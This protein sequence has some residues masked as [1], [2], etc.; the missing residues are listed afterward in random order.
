MSLEKIFGSF[1]RLFAG[2][3]CA[4]KRTGTRRAIAVAAILAVS[5]AASFVVAGTTNASGFTSELVGKLTGGFGLFNSA[6]PAAMATTVVV[7]PESP[8]GWTYV[9]EGGSP[10]GSLVTG[11]GTPPLGIG[12]AQFG[13]SA[14]ADGRYL[15]RA[16]FLGTPLTAIT[17]ISYST[18]RTS[19]TD[20]AYAAAFSFNV[21]FDLT[22]VNTGWQGR[23][24]YE[25]YF[26][27]TVTTGAWQTWN[28]MAGKWVFSQ[29]PGNA[30]CP[31]AVPCT[32]AQVLTAYPN[33]GIHPTFG[34]V[35]FKAGSGWGGFNGNVDSFTLGISGNETTWDFEPSQY[36][37]V[38]DDGAG[39]I[40]DCDDPTP[41]STTLAGALS[42]AN[43]G[44]TIRVC[45]GTYAQASTL[46][47]NVP[48]VTILGLG[49]GKPTVQVASA[50][51]DGITVT[52]SG[53]TIDN[54]AIEKTDL[55]NQDVLRIAANGLTLQNNSIYGPNPGSPWSVNGIVSRAIVGNAGV[56]GFNINNNTISHLRQPG[57][58]SGAFDVAIGSITNNNVSGTRGWVVEGGNITFNGNS[59]GA[60]Q[61]QGCDIAVLNQPGI[62]PA[63]YQPHLA[64]STANNNAFLCT[65]YT[66]G[67]NGRAVAHVSSSAGPGGNGSAAENYQ[68]INAAIPG[69]LIGG[70]VQV[71]AGGYNEDVVINKSVK[72]LGAGQASTTITGPIGGLDGATVRISASNVEV[73]GFTITRAG[74][75][76]TDWNNTGLNFAGVAMI[77]PAIT[78]ANVH[79]NRITGNRTGI[80]VNN[81][82]GNTF[83]RNVITNNRTGF[84]FR[85]QTDN[86]T[87]T[88]N[89]ITNNWTVGVLFLDASSGSNVPVQTAL[90][91]TFTNN[92]ISGNWYGQ[93]VD[94]QTGGSLPAPGTTNL[95]N[96]SGNWIGTTTPTIVAVNSTEPG[97]SAQIPVAYGG[98]AVPPV[99]PQPT[100]AGEASANLDFSPFLNSN[101][102]T[103]AAYGFQ[104]SFSALNISAVSPQ[105]AP[106]GPSSIQE[107]IDA[108]SSG[109]TLNIGSG[110]YA[111]NVNV[112]KAL[113]IKGTF[114]VTG[115]FT[116]SA[117]GVQISPGTSPGIINTGN[118]SL[119][120]N[121]TVNMELNGPTVGTQ[122][123]QLNVTGSVSIAS[124][125]NLNV[126]TGYTPT[127]GTVFT[128]VNNDGADPVSGTFFDMPEGTVFYVGPT[129]LR[130]SYVGGTGNDITLTA[131]SLCNAVSI[132]TTYEVLTGNTVV[133]D[134]NVDDTTGNGLISTDFTLNYDPSV[135]TF[136]AFSLGTVTAGSGT[137]VNSSTPGVLVVSIYSGTPWSGA[138][139][140]ASITFNAVGLPGSS[141]AVSFTSFK[142]NEG[143]PC[144][145]TSN[146]LVTVIGGTITGN[147]TYGNALVGPTPPRYIPDTVITGS[148]SPIVTA[149]SDSSGDY[150]LS[151]FGPGTYT[152]SASKTGGVAGAISAFDAAAVS[153]HVVGLVTLNSTQQTVAEVS[154]S[155]GI[156]SFDAALIARYSVSLPGTGNTGNWIFTPSYGPT[157]VY[158]NITGEDYVGLLMGDVTGNWGPLGPYSFG[159]PAP[160][161]RQD[162]S[163]P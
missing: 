63:F 67:E 157:T 69:T 97:Y 163:R 54:L 138:G 86:L 74:N 133:V 5:V 161:S 87:V 98:T 127:I 129:P 139:S 61:N 114:T 83:H 3:T 104:G 50:I 85:N 73:A 82:N 84:L 77:G 57:Y 2:H 32:W 155:G 140:L 76:T 62:N 30:V 100:L 154:G 16:G 146:G 52:A 79:D 143:T 108:V 17:S 124:N 105:A 135:I 158:S 112:N 122:Y 151:G 4:A 80:D 26:T 131:V 92:N 60:P 56:T 12:S 95:K 118:L 68:S 13:L 123:D 28:P 99:A 160:G 48:G 11:P 116:T 75:N 117:A 8:D 7:R 110:T 94:R 1:R 66:G 147:V 55:P 43:P 88:E 27:E 89:E 59:W 36:I 35:G 64:L 152:R 132:P 23:L 31:M 144:I 38:D 145:S 39:S 148:G 53:V 6:P 141:S 40:T 46:N 153:Q 37:V 126:T 91:S 42:V 19:G 51:G 22:D 34:A 72:V 33:A 150:S 29:A 162:E 142:F 103:S 111:G 96:F 120:S 156:T 24:T 128:I 25:P 119:G 125:V 9:T 121:T 65:Q 101:T 81:S 15:G 134:V 113:H 20:P 21:D 90:N 107:G 115:S 47:I 45:P 102:D 136:N 44:D 109:G 159:L 58:F 71:G 49:P 78:G 106:G 93:I 10:T 149:N 14:A 130:I 18:Y 41:A 70:T 137:F